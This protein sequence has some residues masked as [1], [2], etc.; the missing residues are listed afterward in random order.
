[1]P[2]NA[3]TILDPCSRNTKRHFFTRLAAFEMRMAT[4]DA[5]DWQFRNYVPVF[6]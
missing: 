1:M 4:F 2:E 6:Q 3:A 5:T